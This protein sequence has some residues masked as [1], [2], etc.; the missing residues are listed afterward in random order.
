MYPIASD[1]GVNFILD[2]CKC[3]LWTMASVFDFLKAAQARRKIIV[4]GTLSD[5]GGYTATV[6]ARVARTALEVADTFLFVGLMAPHVLR[7]TSPEHAD[8][9]HAF[10]AQSGSASCRA[11]VGHTV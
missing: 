6:Y 1:D 2:D 8:R 4:I 9:L 5:Y 10:A 11:H 7:A 3:S